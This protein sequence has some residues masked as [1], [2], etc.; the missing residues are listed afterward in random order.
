MVRRIIVGFD[1]SPA[2]TAALTWAAAE[3]RLHRAELVSWTLLDL[4]TDPT[5]PTE[6]HRDETELL[7]ALHRAARSIAGDHPIELHV[8]HGHPAGQLTDACAS[9]DL[10]V[11]GSRGRDPF[12]GLLLGSVS[13]A[14]LHMAPCPVVVVRPRPTPDVPRDRVI[15]GVDGSGTARQAL[16]IAAEEAR[17]RGATLHALH[18]VHWD[19]LG[20][21]LITPT[22]QQLVT[23]GA[24]LVTTELAEA[25]VAA[26]PIIVPGH[27]ADV[28]VRH[29]DHA[30]LLVLGSR[31]QTPLTTL[32]LGSTSAHCAQHATCPVMVVRPQGPAEPPT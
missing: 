26:R 16:R 5:N 12:T 11:V 14:C 7:A 13:R 3:A 31:G 1:G 8:G 17:L 9:D 22:Q 24:Q 18:A 27:A 19:H 25:K 21:E 32:S 28:L 6:P 10:L 15:V 29:S 4:P 20:A 30:D 2:A 23:W